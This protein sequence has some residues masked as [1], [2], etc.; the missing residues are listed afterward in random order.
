M[1]A[2]PLPVE[3]VGHGLISAAV[4]SS[5]LNISVNNLGVDE[6]GQ[7]RIKN[8]H[9]IQNYLFVS[10]PPRPESQI[11]PE[12]GVSLD[13]G[14]PHLVQEEHWCPGH[15]PSTSGRRPVPPPGP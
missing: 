1:V 15:S 10:H 8:K 4:N 5:A 12:Q 14:G 7:V 2:Q 13:G 3:E 9:L 11:T 6:G